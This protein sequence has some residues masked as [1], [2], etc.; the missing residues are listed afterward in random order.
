VVSGTITHGKGKVKSAINYEY[1]LHFPPG[2]LDED[3]NI[4]MTVADRGKVRLTLNPHG[5]QFNV[6][7]TLSLTI[8]SS[9]ENLNHLHKLV[10]IYW[11][12][13]EVSGDGAWVPLGADVNIDGAT[14]TASVD[15]N[16]F[17]QYSLGGHG[18]IQRALSILN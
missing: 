8:R 13:E 2:A 16:H 14:L 10:D 7:V 3:T 6:P 17:S 12:N 5:I 9:E 15:L 18:P 1:R 11:L 4:S